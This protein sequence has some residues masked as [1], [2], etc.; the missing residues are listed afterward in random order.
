LDNFKR[1]LKLLHGLNHN[2]IIKIHGIEKTTNNTYLIL[3]YCNGGNLYEYL[4]FHL[5]KYKSPIPE[6]QIQFIMKQFIQG[7]EYMHKNKIV[8]R[9]IKLENILL[10]F[11]SIPNIYNQNQEQVK[12]DYNKVNIFDCSVKIA[13]LGYARELDGCSVASTICGTPMTM[14]PDI[15]KLS[16]NI[17]LNEKKI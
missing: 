17:G 6:N 4:T 11:D 1:E 12:I 5:N 3:E 7:L 14:A 2:N 15:I 13:D 8:H 16:E 9:D 10:N